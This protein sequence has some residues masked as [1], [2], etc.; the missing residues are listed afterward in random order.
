MYIARI[1]MRK[2]LLAVNPTDSWIA[3]PALERF[4]VALMGSRW[5]A[6]EALP[7]VPEAATGCRAP[8]NGVAAIYCRYPFRRKEERSGSAA[9]SALPI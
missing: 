9:G 1:S 3:E 7:S 6:A 2:R 8:M 4:E 5:M